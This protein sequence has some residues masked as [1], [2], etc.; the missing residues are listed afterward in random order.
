MV[1]N[2][3]F[4]R[5]LYPLKD[6]VLKHRVFQAQRDRINDRLN[7]ILRQEGIRDMSASV[8]NAIIEDSDGDAR[9]A[10]T[11]VQMIATNRNTRAGDSSDARQAMD[12]QATL[13]NIQSKDVSQSI[14]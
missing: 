12:A 1:C 6:I 13:A 14:F 7:Q 2:N 3:G 8:Q 4:D 5:K 11:R 9:S 10:I